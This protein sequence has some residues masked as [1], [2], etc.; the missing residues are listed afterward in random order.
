MPSI[1]EAG[2]LPLGISFSDLG[3]G[4]GVFSGAPL[5]GS[6]GKYSVRL[7]AS[8][9]SGA[10]AQETYALTVSDGTA[11]PT[12][13][14]SKAPSFHQ[15]SY[16]TSVISATG[17]PAPVLSVQR[18]SPSEDSAWSTWEAAVPN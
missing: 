9:A 2:L 15:G 11:A 10:P 16:G 3:N 14:G 18:D 7:T 5:P 12:V 1:S 6:V 13:S 17:K 8:N 4:T